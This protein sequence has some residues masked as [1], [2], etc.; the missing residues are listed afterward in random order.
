M[1][2]ANPIY[3]VVFRYL[4]ADKRAA[5]VLIS[6][7]IGEEI[8]TLDFSAQ[9]RPTPRKILAKGPKAAIE[10]TV[11]RYDFVARI[12]TRDGRHKSVE[13][14]L[15]KAKLP[16]DV[17]RFRHYIGQQYQEQDNAYTDEQGRAKARDLYFIFIL[18][19]GVGA[20]GCPVIR[21]DGA[22]TDLA[23]RKPIRN[24]FAESLHHRSWIVQINQLKEHRRNDLEK[25]LSVFDQAQVIASNKHILEVEEDDEAGMPD[26]YAYLVRCLR[27]ASETNLV[28]KEMENE[29]FYLKD[30]Y[31]A[32]RKAEEKDELVEAQRK[33]IEAKEKTIEEKEKAL[34]AALAE[35]ERLK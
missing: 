31:N 6:A 7:I 11:S 16:S 32:I 8:E 35:I 1:H 27:K 26:G 30:L 18:G 28:R 20:E 24:E 14:E 25:L 5:K 19:Y 23:T 4:M 2:I 34:A 12:K 3:D 15:Q 13:I 17:L 29:D 33:T 21:Y 10:L 9:E 22:A